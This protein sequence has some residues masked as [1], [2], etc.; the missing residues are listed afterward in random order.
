LGGDGMDYKFLEGIVLPAYLT[1]GTV[2]SDLI[3]KHGVVRP[4]S[5]IELASVNKIKPTFSFT[6]FHNT[7]K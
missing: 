4:T 3:E 1:G 7:A 2:R 5:C 6:K